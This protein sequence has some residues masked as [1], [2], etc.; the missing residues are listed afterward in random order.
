MYS[1]TSPKSLGVEGTSSNPYLAQSS[2]SHGQQSLQNTVPRQDPVVDESGPLTALLQHL[3]S[4]IL[5]FEAERLNW[6]ARFETLRLNMPS[7]SSNMHGLRQLLG[8]YIDLSRAV[9]EAK[10]QYLEEQLQRKELEQENHELESKAK[11]ANKNRVGELASVFKEETVEQAISFK[12][13]EKPAKVTKFTSNPPAGSSMS[14]RHHTAAAKGQSRVGSLIDTTKPIKAVYKT[15]VIPKDVIEVPDLDDHNHMD[16]SLAAHVSL[17]TLKTEEVLQKESEIR[18]LEDYA[19]RLRDEIDHRSKEAATKHREVLAKLARTETRTK[20][21]EDNARKLNEEYFDQRKKHDQ[22]IRRLQEE[23]ELLKLKGT[24]LKK[25]YEEAKLGKT[26]ENA[27]T[28]D[29]AGKRAKEYA[30][31]FKTKSRRKE[32]ALEIVREQYKKVKA[33]YTDKIFSLQEAVLMLRSE[34]EKMVNQAENKSTKERAIAAAARKL[35]KSLIREV[36]VRGLGGEWKV[37]NEDNE[38]D[39]EDTI[40]LEDLDRLNYKMRNINRKLKET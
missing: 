18:I 29:L 3:H 33:I 17:A 12:K 31:G 30:D 2:N 32:E 23:K 35:L 25:Q 20:I 21:I 19:E 14:L 40:N 37:E 16:Q 9:S 27:I 4:K 39:Q 36:E 8:E 11:H 1:S 6:L 15:V 13:G 24:S 5:A 7:R 38:G 22:E 28:K 34:T 10:V 26:L